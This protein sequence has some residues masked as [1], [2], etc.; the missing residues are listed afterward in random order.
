MKE[1]DFMSSLHKKT[2]RDYI[3]RVND[4]VYPKSKAAKLAKKFDFDYWDGDRR[5]CYGGY[6]YIPGRWTEVAKKII[7]HYDLKEES[8]ILD[9]MCGIAGFLSP[10]SFNK[11]ELDPI[12]IKMSDRLIHR[13]P[14]DSGTWL[15]GEAGIAL[16]HR[17][18]LGLSTNRGRTCRISHS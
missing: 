3:A 16:A 17:R 8:K 11:D 7:K 9:L 15:D 2:K 1:I 6:K 14:D 12:A 10:Q 18:G 13:G 4:P 5:I